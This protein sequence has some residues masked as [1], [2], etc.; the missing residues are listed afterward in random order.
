MSVEGSG[1]FQD[2]ADEEADAAQEALLDIAV[3]EEKN[4]CGCTVRTMRI[5]MAVFF[6]LGI[7][8]FGSGVGSQVFILVTFAYIFLIICLVCC[9]IYWLPFCQPPKGADE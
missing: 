1:M 3:V 6:A 7:I 9:C 2:D 8:F 4:R 5:L